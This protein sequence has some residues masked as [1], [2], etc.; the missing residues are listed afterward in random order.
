MASPLQLP[1]L[2]AGTAIGGAAV[3]AFEP[4]LEVPRQQAWSTAPN[5]LPDIGLI[6]ALVAGGKVALADGQ[7]MAARLGYDTGPF[8]SLTWLAQN[9]LDWPLVLRMWRL[10]AHFPAFA[11]LDAAGLIDRTLAHEQLDWDYQP[12]LRALQTAELPGIGDIAYA[13]VRGYLPTDIPL[14]VPPPATSTN[15][16]RFP[17]STTKAEELAAALGYDVSML[18]LLIA[19]SG[20][21]M[22]PGLAAQG[23]FRGV[24]ADDDYHLAIAEGDL[25]TEWADALRET[26]RAI[27][28]P[29]E[30]AELWLRGWLTQ[31][32]A[33]S[34]AARHG[35]V[36]GDTDLLYQLR[37]RPLNPHQIKQALAR[38]GVFDTTNAPFND[39][40]LSSVHEANLG[41]EWYDLA[42]QLQG[43]Y[44]SLFITNRLVTTNVID[45]ATGKDWLTK[46]GLADEVVAAMDSSWTGGTTSTADKN[47]TS[48]QT[49]V[50][51]T[52]H[53]SYLAY[54]ISDQTATTALEAA[55]VAAAS[56]PAI[57]SLYQTE[58]DL[59]RKSLTAANIKKAVTDG[60]TNPATG[61]AWTH[62]DA[63]AALLQLGYSNDS[64]TVYLEL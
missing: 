2:I 33:E 14:P 35:M 47:V 39:P 25:R 11:G 29:G 37:R 59:I 26:S 1:S 49:H 30:Y 56:V 50:K 22:A 54:E 58:R 19:R 4:A 27:P 55:G 44:P 8:D 48:A 7:S 24:L 9:R 28:S 23:F 20:L 51:T 16:K 3:A 45:A 57:L 13:V 53:K 31:A 61:V 64:A 32:Q 41:P 15:V 36:P 34:G 42:I 63:I 52:V 46:S 60:V 18:E 12:Y 43:S 17:Q 10:G 38:G 5:R 6:A 40:Y 21:S 62:A